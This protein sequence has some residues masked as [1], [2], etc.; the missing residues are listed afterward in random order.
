MADKTKIKRSKLAMFLDTS[1]GE[2]TAAYA[3]IGDGDDRADHRLQPHHFGGNLHP[4]GYR[5]HRRG[6][7]PTQH[8]HPHDRHQGG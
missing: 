6:E 5:H 1:G 3:L 8:P 4:S 2:E 7:L